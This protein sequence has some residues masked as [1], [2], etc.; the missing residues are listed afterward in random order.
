MLG[1]EEVTRLQ[2][3]GDQWLGDHDDALSVA[4]SDRRQ[5]GR[6]ERRV[7]SQQQARGGYLEDRRRDIRHVAGVLRRLRGEQDTKLVAG[8]AERA[9]QLLTAGGGAREFVIAGLTNDVAPVL[10][11][12]SRG[13]KGPEKRAGHGD[14]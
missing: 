7:R 6:R 8:K 10:G 13:Q 5:R 9:A 14:V 1:D 2:Q 3:I 12:T 4:I 11:R